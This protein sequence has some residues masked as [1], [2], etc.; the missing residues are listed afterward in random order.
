MEHRRQPFT[1]DAE[2]EHTVK[3]HLA[4]ILG[5]CE[6]LIGDTPPEDPRRA[7][8]E[9]VHRSARALMEIFRRE[10]HP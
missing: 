3:N 10:P 2:T 9:E 7:D 8:L 4:V 1:L 6:L 5:F